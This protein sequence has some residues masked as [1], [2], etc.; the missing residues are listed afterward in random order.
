MIS[1]KGVCCS[2][3]DCSFGLSK[4]S[5]VWIC[6]MCVDAKKL[7][8]AVNSARDERKVTRRQVGASRPHQHSNS[9]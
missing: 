4:H 1:N 7:D 3:G 9:R 2:C 8:I 6:P 5:G